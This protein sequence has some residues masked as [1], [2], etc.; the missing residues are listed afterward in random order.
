MI[1]IISP[2]RPLLLGL[3]SLA[4]LAASAAE[5]Q[6]VDYQAPLAPPAGSPVFTPPEDRDIPDNEF[7]AA[8][9]F[10]RDIFMN[11]PRHAS[12]YVGN[13]LSCVNCHLDR[14]RLADS[15]PLWA[16][17]VSYPAYRKKNDRVNTYEERLQ[18]CFSYSMNGMP[19]PSGSKELVALVA[20]SYWMASG[21]PTGAKLAGRGY[22]DLP[23][24]PKA[25]NFKRGARVYETHCAICHGA[26]GEGT[27]AG[28]RYAFPPLWGNDSFNW[29][30]GM[31]RINTAA[32]F[33]QANMPLG[34]G[35]SLSDQE[36]WDVAAFVDGHDRPQDPRYKGSLNDT[37]KKF[38][39]EQCSYGDSIDGKLLGADSVPA[40]GRTRR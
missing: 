14:G 5:A 20:Y 9:R 30:A 37:K 36:A 22:K 40:G 8:I 25:P 11:S 32:G 29:G 13:G 35:N 6:R 18:G 33:I 7:G 24:P 31:H 17:Y 2:I 26:N 1:A 27:K 28:E 34:R 10:G 3:L 4:S 21:A 39:D 15:A 19:P 16:A 12:Q 23:A 38:H